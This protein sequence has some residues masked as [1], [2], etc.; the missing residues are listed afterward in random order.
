M[1]INIF[2]GATVSKLTI[3]GLFRGKRILDVKKLS[4]GWYLIKTKIKSLPGF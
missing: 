1:K 3:G 4:N 2:V